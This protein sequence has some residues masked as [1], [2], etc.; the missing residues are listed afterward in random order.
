MLLHLPPLI[1][2]G[3]ISRVPSEQCRLSAALDSERNLLVRMTSILPISLTPLVFNRMRT[4]INVQSLIEGNLRSTPTYLQ[5]S[6]A[7]TE[8]PRTLRLFAMM[9]LEDIEIPTSQLSQY[10]RRKVRKR[11]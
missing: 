10:T 3:L 7:A 5:F 4:S 2:A 1:T 11:R 9:P 8:S 6:L